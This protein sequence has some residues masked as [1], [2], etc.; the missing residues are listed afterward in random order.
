MLVFFSSRC[1]CFHNRSASFSGLAAAA[2]AAASFAGLAAAAGAAA[3][4]LLFPFANRPLRGAFARRQE[5]MGFPAVIR[6]PLLQH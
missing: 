1:L 6:F 5:N 4:F 3:T 2:G